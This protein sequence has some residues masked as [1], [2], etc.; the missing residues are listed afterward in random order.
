MLFQGPPPSSATASR[1]PGQ[2]GASARR[3]L[4]AEDNTPDEDTADGCF[5]TAHL[6]GTGDGFATA[7]GFGARPRGFGAAPNEDEPAP[8]EALGA[9]A[10]MPSPRE[11]CIIFGLAN[12]TGMPR[13]RPGFT[14][15]PLSEALEKATPEACLDAIFAIAAGGSA[16]EIL[17]AAKGTIHRRPFDDERYYR[18]IAAW[19]GCRFDTGAA[20]E[21]LAR[22]RD[23]KVVYKDDGALLHVVEE[24]ARLLIMTPAPS[25]LPRLA[26]LVCRQPEV[27]DHVMIVPP[28]A[29]SRLPS[30][31]GATVFRGRLDPLHDVP[32]QEVADK[33]FTKGQVAAFAAAVT[34]VLAAAIAA[35]SALA[36]VGLVSVNFALF[37]YAATRALAIAH[38]KHIHPPRQRLR[39]SQ[40]PDYTILVPL[41]R[42]DEGLIQLVRALRRLDYP[43]EKL[44]IQFLVEA[45][46]LTTQRAVAHAARYLNCRMSVVPEGSPRTKPRALNV[47]LR[48]ARGEI[49]T[50]YDA[51]DRPDP[52]Q[53]RIA[54]ETFAAAPPELAALQAR[55]TID[56]VRDNWLT[57]MFAIEYA[58]LFDHILPMV[59][60]RKRLILLGGTS[61]H[62]RVD[63]LK[64]VG[65]WD[66]YNVT[67]DADLGVRLGRS[68]YRIA[69]IDSDTFEE[70]P[71]TMSAWLKQRSRWF[72][73]W[74]QTWLVHHRNPITLV[75][76]LG[77]VDA[78]VFN[79]YIV[80]GLLAAVAH[81][82]F[83]TQIG[84]AMA[85]VGSVLSGPAG[86]LSMVQIGVFAFGYGAS[87]ALGAVSAARH[88]TSGVGV[89]AVVWFP[90]Y[91][92][93]M[94]MA[95]VI[96]LHD[97]IRHP[98]HWRK[99]THGLAKRPRLAGRTKALPRA[100][101]AARA[102]TGAATSGADGAATHPWPPSSALYDEPPPLQAGTG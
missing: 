76:E 42:E 40:L 101:H 94:G 8:A 27:A 5:S 96:A 86:W 85:G 92:I 28:E 37:A 77:V 47:G 26:A 6:F 34:A 10:K 100:P 74:L 53:L 56:H 50:I 31:S 44:D 91:W 29:L 63:A 48:Q 9:Q 54:A 3:G 19:L 23:A 87:L 30:A 71:L 58:C 32:P 84:L 12:K 61:N 62:F 98:H 45:D 24:G 67:E 88:R 95:V 99:T 68:G 55:L 102:L 57:R 18:A 78:C 22:G 13:R 79:L 83:A 49:V 2:E 89:F 90:F 1:S 65:G 4:G 17:K 82:A 43:R 80:G 25:W 7:D 21:R 39:S 51:E 36:M 72:K 16:R 93:L 11:A 52:M 64:E 60:A 15:R 66:P 35:P 75:R 14:P 59:A 97:L 20:V 33:V 73:G 46:D 81:L 41:Y 69:M 38:R 70:A